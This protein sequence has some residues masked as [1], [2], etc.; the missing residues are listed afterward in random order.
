M[1]GTLKGYLT[2]AAIVLMVV[3]P[4]FAD[5]KGGMIFLI[6]IVIGYCFVILPSQVSSDSSRV[7]EY[8]NQPGT[9]QD[10]RQITEEHHHYHIHQAPKGYAASE[11]EI[12]SLNGKTA[13]IRKVERFE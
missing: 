2:A 13:R 3:V 7:S 4:L 12:Y 10:S 1:S 5:F 11:A 8:W 9:I 6:F